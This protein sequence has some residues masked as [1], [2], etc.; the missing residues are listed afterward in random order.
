MLSPERLELRAQRAAGQSA[1]ERRHHADLRL[2]QRRQH[3]Q[4][5]VAGN[6]DV[7]VVDDDVLVAGLRQHLR[8]IAD[9][10]IEAERC[11]Q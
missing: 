8:K 2:C 6:Q 7:A 5:V 3:A 4:Q 11:G 1:I 9:L 10:A